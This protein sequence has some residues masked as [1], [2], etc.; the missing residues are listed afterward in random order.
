[1]IEQSIPPIQ[2]ERPEK[3]HH[4]KMLAT[5]VL[6]LIFSHLSAL[7]MNQPAA[8]WLNAQYAYYEMPFSF[9]LIGGPWLFLGI[10]VLYLTVVSFLLRRLHGAASLVLTAALTMSHSLALYWTLSCGFHGLYEAHR[11]IACYS[12]RFV[13]WI[14]FNVIFVLILL[15]KHLPERLTYWGKRIGIP[16]AALWVLLMGYGIFQAAFPTSSAWKPIAPAHTPGPR[17]MTAIAYDSD[18]QRAVLFGGITGWDGNEW[19]YDNSTWEWDGQDWYEIESPVAPTGR[20]LHAMAYDEQRKKVIL[21]G[22]EKAS[23]ALSDLWEWDGTTWHQL[24]PVCNPAARMGHKM[25]YD[26]R[27]QQIVVYGGW[28]K[29]IG[30]PEAWTWDGKTWTYFSFE[31][32]APATYNAPMIYDTHNERAVSFMGN[33]WGGTWIWKD[34]IWRTLDSGLQP[35]MRD[36]ATLVYNPETDQIVLAGGINNSDTLYNDTWIL[37]GETW[38]KLDLPSS[39]PQ[40]HLAAAFYDPIRH[41]IILYGG[42]IMGSIYNDMWELTLPEGNQP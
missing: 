6:F 21:Y 23:G 40:R 33:T 7:L 17:T 8:Y 5:L 39:P 3:L 12:F 2:E 41:S 22:G 42:E 36:E 16:I 28:N 24:C 11:A 38:E 26:E 18:R 31:S 15:I 10:A 19:V 37:D 4:P 30:F 20:S 34:S 13:P 9:L 32:S 1:M 27:L 25:F 14:V 29:D 35:P